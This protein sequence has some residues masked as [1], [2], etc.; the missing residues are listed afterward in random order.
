[1]YD[2]IYDWILIP[3]RLKDPIS[4]KVPLSRVT[5][6]ESDELSMINCSKYDFTMDFTFDAEVQKVVKVEEIKQK[7][8]KKVKEIKDT[9]KRA[10]S[11]IKPAKG[12]KGKDDC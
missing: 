9:R 6:K 12:K 1:L 10:G 8:E 5:K 11:E 7:E 3:L 4:S 2:H